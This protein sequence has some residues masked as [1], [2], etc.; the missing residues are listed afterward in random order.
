MQH[1]VTS[2]ELFWVGGLAAAICVALCCLILSIPP[3]K[4]GWIMVT[5]APLH[6]S[7]IILSAALFL[8]IGYIWL[9]VGSSRP[10]GTSQMRIAFWLSVI[11]GAGSVVA[12]FQTIRIMRSA[13]SL[14]GNEIAFQ[15][16]GDQILLRCSDVIFGER[17]WGGEIRFGF[18]DGTIL[19]VD[20]YALN[21]DRLIERLADQLAVLRR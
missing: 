12:A 19:D 16:A 17:R 15:K 13:L 1:Y 6:W 2:L 11:F 18:D 5:P 8:F 10:D 20:P 9:F 14:R 21:A 3:K 4:P 7:A